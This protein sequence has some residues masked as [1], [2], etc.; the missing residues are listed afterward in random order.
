MRQGSGQ[1]VDKGEDRLFGDMFL[2]I[3]RTLNPKRE[4]Q[5]YREIH[6]G[7][8]DVAIADGVATLEKFAVQSKTMTVLV[9]GNVDFNTEKLKLAIRAKPREGLG[10]SL[11][12]SVNSFLRLGGTL[13][14][15]KLQID[16][17]GSAFTG[18]AAVAT[19]GFSL[20]AKAL[21]DRMSGQMDICKADVKAKKN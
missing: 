16:P 3:L 10:V 2:T 13:R 14:S 15:P 8:Y 1:I 19:G 21:Y 17:K 5:V 4:K 12:G 20:L 18:G 11:G 6:C 9:V 7:I